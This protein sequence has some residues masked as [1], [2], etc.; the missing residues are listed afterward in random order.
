M[1]PLTL[2]KVFGDR[3]LKFVRNNLHM[4]GS[5]STEQNFDES[6]VVKKATFTKG[7]FFIQ[8]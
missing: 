5:K 1:S 6:W 4:N 7:F 8:V 3:G 2:S